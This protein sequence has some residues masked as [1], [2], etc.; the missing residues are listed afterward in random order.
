ME[1]DMRATYAETITKTEA[2]HTLVLEEPCYFDDIFFKNRS[3][4]S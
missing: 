4:N 3:L 2:E 1:K